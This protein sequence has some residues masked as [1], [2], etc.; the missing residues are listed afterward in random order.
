[1]ERSGRRR[2]TPIDTFIQLSV[3]LRP[4]AVD[5]LCLNLVYFVIKYRPSTI[6]L[7]LL[8][9]GS[10]DCACPLCRSSQLVIDIPLF[11]SRYRFFNFIVCIF[12]P[13]DNQRILWLTIH[14]LVL[15]K[16]QGYR[17]FL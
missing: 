16:C 8:S 15:P 10:L 2:A 13:R 4:R 5:L 14:C 17:R 7:K 12:H 1:M 3:P 11:L 9:L 6:T